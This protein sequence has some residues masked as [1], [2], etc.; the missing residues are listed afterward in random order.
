MD[1]DDYQRRAAETMSMSEGAPQD[2]LEPMLGLASETGSILNVYKKRLRDSVDITSHRAFLKEDLGDLLWYLAVVARNYDLTL[3]EVAEENLRRAQSNYA[4]NDAATAII[5]SAPIF[6][7]DFPMQERFPRIVQ[8]AFRQSKD[9]KFA[10][11][12][13]TQADPYPFPEGQIADQDGRLVGFNLNTPFGD[14]LTDNSRRSD[15]YR[16]HDAIHLAFMAV[17]GWSPSMRSLLRLKRKSDPRVDE[18]EDGARAIFADEG[19]AAILAKLSEEHNGF[20]EERYVDTETIR[21]VRTVAAGLEVEDLPGLLWRR[22]ISQGFQAMHSLVVNHG[23]I[24][25]ADLDARTL[26]YSQIPG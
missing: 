19:I 1:L 10:S 25:R 4:K 17:L 26:K 3:N 8:V 5:A 24:L 23:G 11:M 6:D 14:E 13:I 22:A 15:G 7:I 21:I 12:A 9:S 20:R 18:V 2:L 16:F